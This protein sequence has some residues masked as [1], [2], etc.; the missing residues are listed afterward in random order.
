MRHLIDFID[1]WAPKRVMVV[2]DFMLD[3]YVYGN[4]ERM[5]P[6]APVPVLSVEREEHRPGG[7]S[8][9]SMYL[10]ALH[11]DVSCIGVIGNDSAGEEL[12]AS[13]QDEGC[14]TRGLLAVAGRVTT[15]KQSFVGLAQHRHPQKM[16]RADFE[17]ADPID[18]ATFK[19]LLEIADTALPRVDVLCFEDYDKG[20]LTEA[21]CQA[22]IEIAK[23]HGV[24]V[25]VDPAA[26]SDYHKYA[27]ATAITPNRTEAALATGGPADDEADLRGVAETL[28]RD[29][30]LKTVLITL[31][32]H[33]ALLYQ[34]DGEPHTVPTVARTV[35]DVTGA[36]DM[37]LAMNAAAIANGADWQTAAELANVAAGL[38]VE[39]F[40]V[41]T[42]PLEDIHVSLLELN[43]DTVGKLRSLDQLL[44][45]LNA[46]RK[47]GKKVAFTNGCFDLLHAGHIDLLRGARAK[48]D[49][50]VLAVNSDRSICAIKGPDR[51]IV[52]E[53]ERVKVLGE[54]DCVDYIILF[55]DGR[56][57]EE[58]TPRPLLDAIQP[59]VLVKGGDY[60]HDEVV[61]WEIVEAYG[62]KVITIPPVPGVSTTNI[63]ER[64]R[65]QNGEQADG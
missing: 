40:G 51:P 61:G 4:A 5:S 14:D 1:G 34:R 7:A 44:S 19:Q 53:A 26:I 60:R 56:G 49:L 22:L 3:H 13:L 29:L 63:V 31:D 6:D 36:G 35:Y 21:C 65:T 32:R 45:E 50:L 46:Y 58:D 30:D 41:A 24:P 59:E 27:G 12:C 17:R 10:R 15:V 64:I 52:P 48:A 62:G 39:R 20:V 54:L 47:Q 28:L 8:N 33:G 38:E 25:L 57:T 18:A 42:I 43:S 37:V 23:K 55:G 11:C 9:V 16:F 2:G